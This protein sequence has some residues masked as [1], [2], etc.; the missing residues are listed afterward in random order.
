MTAKS[1]GDLARGFASGGK[2]LEATYEVPYL[3]HAPMEPLNATAHVQQDRVDVWMGTQ[4]ADAAL[5]RAAKTA[6]VKPEQVYVHNCFL[7]GG[8]G[9]RSVNDE[10]AQA[11]TISKAVGKPVKVFWTREEDMRHDRYRP[12]GGDP[13][14]GSA[15][16]GW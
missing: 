7:G 2:V 4:N 11:V 3:A 10:L 5:Q 13:L 8:F 15:R 1:T 9:R 6:G 12:A 14:Q 16:R